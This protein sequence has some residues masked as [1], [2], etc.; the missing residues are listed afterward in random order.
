LNIQPLEHIVII[1]L[2]QPLAHIERKPF[3][4]FT[5]EKITYNQ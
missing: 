4:W 1:K 5:L 3:G 2:L